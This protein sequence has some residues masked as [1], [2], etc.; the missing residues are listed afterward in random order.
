MAKGFGRQRA[1]ARPVRAFRLPEGC[2]VTLCPSGVSA[3]SNVAPIQLSLPRRQLSTWH[4]FCIYQEQGEVR[5][6]RTFTF[7]SC[8]QGLF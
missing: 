2:G 1:L 6:L 8:F 4:I 7:N 3:M 5:V